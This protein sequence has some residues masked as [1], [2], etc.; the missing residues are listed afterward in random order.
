MLSG[1]D[2]PQCVIA[3]KI[4]T[5]GALDRSTI[6]V[7][8]ST[9]VNTPRLHN[10]LHTNTSS[11]PSTSYQQ[12]MNIAS[13]QSP[14]QHIHTLAHRYNKS[15]HHHINIGI[16]SP[17]HR[18]FSQSSTGQHFNTSTQSFTADEQH[19]NRPIHHHVST[20]PRQTHAHTSASTTASINSSINTSIYASNTSTDMYTSSP[21]HV[22]SF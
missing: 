3:K 22:L 8:S 2:V 9:L 4:K 21:K 18:P 19:I 11:L 12:N 17:T 14:M 20:S 1:D 7:L 5:T 16:K 15:T 13:T 10:P 6:D